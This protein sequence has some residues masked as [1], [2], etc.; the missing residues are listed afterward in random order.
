MCTFKPFDIIYITMKI[1]VPSHHK[2]FLKNA[3][4]LQL[5]RDSFSASSLAGETGRSYG[6]TSNTLTSMLRSG[7]VRK[8]TERRVLGPGGKSGIRGLA[9]ARYGLTSEGRSGIRVVLTGGVFDIL[10]PGHIAMLE[11]AR[12]HGDVLVVVVARDSVIRKRKKIPVNTEDDRLLVVSSLK[13]VDAA[14]LGSTRSYAETL[15]R[16]RPDVVSLGYDQDSDLARLERLTAGTSPRQ[17]G[18]GIKAEIVRTSRFSPEHS[19]TGILRRIR[20]HH[21][22]GQA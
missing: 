8:V 13:H 12:S 4:V 19:T 18:R 11:E 9:P 2:E 6:Y 14:I 16:I 17:A 1:Q 22:S 5:E 7:L 21:E 10:H 20:H 15:E 3:Y